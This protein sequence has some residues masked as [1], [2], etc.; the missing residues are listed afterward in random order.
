MKTSGDFPLPPFPDP[1]ML[2]GDGIYARGHRPGGCGHERPWWL[3]ECLECSNA[4]RDKIYDGE[5][6]DWNNLKKWHQKLGPEM[7]LADIPI[8]VCLIGDDPLTESELEYCRQIAA[9]L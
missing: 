1:N 4:R 6:P 5:W 9:R 7:K 2:W 8:E 3:D